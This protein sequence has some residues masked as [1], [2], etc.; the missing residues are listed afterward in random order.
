KLRDPK[1]LQLLSYFLLLHKQDKVPKKN[2]LLNLLL[3]VDFESPGATAVDLLQNCVCSSSSSL[4]RCHRHPGFWSLERS[5]AVSCKHKEEE[6]P[7]AARTENRRL[8]WNH[9]RPAK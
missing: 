8:R 7:A 5:F 4:R 3:V 9:L 2:Y 1:F 6:P